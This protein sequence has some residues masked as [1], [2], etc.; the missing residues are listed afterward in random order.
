M[1]PE[2]RKKEHFLKKNKKKGPS[3]WLGAQKS[4]TLGPETKK[5]LR[6]FLVFCFFRLGPEIKIL[7]RIYTRGESDKTFL[8]ASFCLTFLKLF[9]CQNNNDNLMVS[10]YGGG[11]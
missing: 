10:W 1:G 2:I 5:W 3:L 9:I 8:V 4:L 7:G 11:G 6:F